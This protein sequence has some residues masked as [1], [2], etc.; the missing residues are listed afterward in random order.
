MFLDV[1][2]EE[3]MRRAS[4]RWECPQCSWVGAIRD[5][6]D[7]PSCGAKVVQR[8]DDEPASIRKRI[9]VYEDLTLPVVEYFAE[10][11]RLIRVS[12]VGS[13][14]EVFKRVLTGLDYDENDGQET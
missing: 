11:S 10:T 2:H 4:E 9:A 6:G 14:E 8:P 5:C 13:G 12:G 7:C 1:P 3:L